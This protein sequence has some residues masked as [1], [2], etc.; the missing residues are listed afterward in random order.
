M[1][2]KHENIIATGVSMVLQAKYFGLDRA[3]QSC[4]QEVANEL[5]S[6]GLISEAAKNKPSYESIDREF[7]SGMTFIKEV[8]K[9]KEHCQTFIDILSAQG[10]AAKIAAE[11]LAEEWRETV[12]KEFG[13]LFKLEV[14]KNAATKRTMENESPGTSAS[15]IFKLDKEEEVKE[16]LKSLH[17]SFVQLRRRIREE[18]DKKIKEEISF[19]EVTIFMQ[20]YITRAEDDFTNIKD[21]DELFKVLL[22]YSDFLDCDV[23]KAITE[24]FIKGD[25]L[26]ELQAHS[27]KAVDFRKTQS[28]TIL[29][30]YL[31]NAYSSPSA[32]TN[33]PKAIIH[34]SEP[35]E[36]VVI[37]N[38]YTLMKHL[39]PKL[40]GQSLTNHIK[41]YPGSVHIEYIVQEAQCDSL[42]AHAQEKL[43]FMHFIGIFHFAINGKR[44]LDEEENMNFTFNSGLLEAVKVGDTEAVSFLI[45]LGA[46]IDYQDEEG[47]SALM[48]A[49][50]NKSI[51]IVKLL[52]EF[53][54]NLSLTTANG[55]T[56]LILSVIRNSHELVQLLLDKDDKLL[57]TELTTACKC[58][59]SNIVNL[60]VTWIDN[61]S[62]EEA[63]ISFRGDLTSLRFLITYLNTHPSLN[64]DAKSKDDDRSSVF[65]VDSGKILHIELIEFLP[66]FNI[67]IHLYRQRIIHCNS[68]Q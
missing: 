42:I 38:L 51:E 28:V 50:E 11:N 47:K 37:E 59:L 32:L 9:L 29:R 54:A 14:R 6:A 58:G 53:N 12:Q 26:K 25:L 43:Q 15:K 41:I 8:S 34:L 7:Q 40:E 45:K 65:S 31:R 44:I 46:N 4:I 1:D 22:R 3:L 33:A 62:P 39:L 21:L 64:Y 17:K 5:F 19:K 60:F 18:L 56:A 27:E 63:E 30:D 68:V 13:I 61:L 23:L 10:G 55:H 20:D 35:W 66:V 57:I 36:N 52:L 16:T 24:E 2:R 48:N 67:I 49:C